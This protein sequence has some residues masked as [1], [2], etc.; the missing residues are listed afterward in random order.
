MDDEARL[1]LVSVGFRRDGRED[2]IAEYVRYDAG[3]EESRNRRLQFVCVGVR[4]SMCQ[5][6]NWRLLRACPEAGSVDYGFRIKTFV[7]S[8]EELVVA[9]VLLLLLRRQRTTLLWQRRER[10]TRWWP[11]AGR[12]LRWAMGRHFDCAWFGVETKVC[13]DRLTSDIEV[14]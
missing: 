7:A 2:I 12:K 11:W 14:E 1:R 3:E 4:I 13:R 10:T 5:L 6:R 9:V 8:W